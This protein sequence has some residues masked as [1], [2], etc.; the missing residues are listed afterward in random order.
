MDYMAFR[1]TFDLLSSVWKSPTI[2]KTPISSALVGE[3]DKIGK[4]GRD[5]IAVMGISARKFRG[6]QIHDVPRLGGGL[7][8]R[9]SLNRQQLAFQHLLPLA[10]LPC[11]GFNL[12]KRTPDVGGFLRGHAAMFIEIERLVTHEA[13]ASI[14]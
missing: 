7:R 8:P 14:R 9:L 12:G 11:V 13:L 3:P 10:Q 5:Q 1:L 6:I 2:R 4:D